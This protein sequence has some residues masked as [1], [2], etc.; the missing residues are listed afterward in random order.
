[1]IAIITIDTA[2]P[3]GALSCRVNSCWI[4]L[5][6]IVPPGPPTSVGVLW[7]GR[8]PFDPLTTAATSAG[9][10]MGVHVSFAKHGEQGVVLRGVAQGIV[11]TFGADEVPSGGVLDVAVR[12]TEEVE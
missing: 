9:T 1:M 8:V 10:G 2:A 5:P 11:L 7:A 3:I 12:Y 4:R 6:I